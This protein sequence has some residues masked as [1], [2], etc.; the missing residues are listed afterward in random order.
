[1]VAAVNFMKSLACALALLMAAGPVMADRLKDLT[2][3]QGVR[4]NQLIGYGLVAPLG[5]RPTLG[6]FTVIRE[7]SCP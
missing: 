5:M 2:R 1:M 7:P 3:V 4:N 6:T